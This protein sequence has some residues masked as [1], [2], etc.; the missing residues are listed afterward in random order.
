MA[1]R[2]RQHNVAQR[3][4]FLKEIQGGVEV[5]GNDQAC[6][7]GRAGCDKSHPCLIVVLEL[8]W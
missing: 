2:N 7:H 3:S 8:I 1:M 6:A 5:S 4:T